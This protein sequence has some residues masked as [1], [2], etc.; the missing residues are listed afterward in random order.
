MIDL[1]AGKPIGESQV[2]RTHV[3]INFNASSTRM[4]LVLSGTALYRPKVRNLRIVIT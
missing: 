1:T 2:E 3:L 4:K